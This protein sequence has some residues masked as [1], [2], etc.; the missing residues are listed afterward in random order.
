MGDPGVRASPDNAG[1]VLVRLQGRDT[2]N[3][4]LLVIL[5]W[6]G[7]DDPQV[8]V[9][10]RQEGEARFHLSPPEK[11]VEEP[12]VGLIPLNRLC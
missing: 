9:Q 12:A 4:D 7:K 2:D 1:L 10:F 5:G 8:P 6:I 3:Q 11:L